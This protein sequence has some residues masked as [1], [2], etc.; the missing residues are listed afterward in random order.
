MNE[1]DE[2]WEVISAADY[3]RLRLSAKREESDMEYIIALQRAIEYHSKGKVIPADI[4]EKCP[5]HANMLNA[6]LTAELEVLQKAI[7]QLEN[8]AH[9]HRDDY[10]LEDELLPELRVTLE[11]G[12]A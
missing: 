7:P 12:Q 6:A 4:V 10:F 3:A 1:L 8:C 5:H 2:N 9:H 11:Q